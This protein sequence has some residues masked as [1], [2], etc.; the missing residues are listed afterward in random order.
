EKLASYMSGAGSRPLPEAVALETKHHILDTLAAAISGS[1]LPPGIQALKFAKT[2]GGSGP[3]TIIST[4]MTAGPLEAAI[5]NGE[6]AQADETDDNYSVGGAHPGCAV[7][8][9]ALAMAETM[10]SDGKLF[11]NAVTLGYD[12]GMRAMKTFFG[13][14]VLRDMH[15]IVGT[16]G[17]AAAAG[18][19]ARLNQQQMRWLVGYASQQAASAYGA[20]ARGT[21]HIGKGLRVRAMKP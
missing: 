5:V 1:E 21:E 12:I 11:L 16:F 15:S 7:I 2:Y 19:L 10:G 6:L 8:P 14:T 3:A 17:A 20:W 18:S 13:R 4:G 9:A